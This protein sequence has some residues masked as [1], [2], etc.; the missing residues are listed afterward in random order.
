MPVR[1]AVIGG[2]VIRNLR[3]FRGE[4]VRRITTPHG[5]PSSAV[6]VGRLGAVEV[7]FVCRHG[8]GH[9]IPPHRI[10]HRANLWALKELGVRRVLATASVGSLKRD[11]RPGSVAVPDDF[12]CPWSFPAFRDDE[13][14]RATPVLDAGMRKAIV[15]AV[16]REGVRARARAVYAQ[17]RG[18]RLETK[19]EIRFLRDY[20]DIVGMTLA[21]EATLAAEMD[22]TYASVCTVDNYAHGITDRPLS[23]EAIA[24][25]QRKNAEMLV[26]LLDRV[27][28]ALASDT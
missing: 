20:A 19:A 24:E 1:L 3:D 26:A 2:S 4:T 7:A 15:T 14:A 11:I 21:S 23:Y 22:V 10:N 28:S 16:E 5:P 9:T 8:V 27:L 17:T 6:Q 25:T 18:P 13:V 12:F